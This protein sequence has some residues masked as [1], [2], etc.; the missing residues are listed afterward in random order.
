[1]TTFREIITAPPAALEKIFTPLVQAAGAKASGAARLDGVARVARMHPEQILV[2]LGFNRGLRADPAVLSVLRIESYEDL[3]QQRNEIFIRDVYVKLCFE[4][5]MT[6]YTTV[7]DDP[8]LIPILQYL[9]HR[10]LQHI[11]ERIE[12]TINPVVIDRYRKE[13]KAIY[14]E[15]IAQIEFAEERLDKTESGFRALVNEVNVIVDAKLIPLGDIFF[16]ASVLPEEKRRLIQRGLI[17]KD[18]ILARKRDPAIPHAEQAM[19][20]R[21]LQEETDQG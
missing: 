5:V 3:A 8:D 9:L 2:A 17:P 11:E 21:W 1:M 6:V 13:I 10:R 15:G 14:G 16:R 20:D 7:K 4:N 18:L 12:A 19:L